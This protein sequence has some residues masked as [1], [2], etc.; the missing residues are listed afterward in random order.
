V[1]EERAISPTGERLSPKGRVRTKY[2][3]YVDQHIL[4]LE[5]E[6]KNQMEILVNDNDTLTIVAK[7]DLNVAD[8]MGDYP[9]I[10]ASYR[11]VA[12]LGNISN[13]TLEL[14][15]LGAVVPLLRSE[16]RVEAGKLPAY[17]D[18]YGTDRIT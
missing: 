9:A 8:P 3:G 2:Y 18:Y 5:R 15:R 16:R 1:S 11:I 13:P 10:A 6:G 17:T 4:R 7:I 12:N 14:V